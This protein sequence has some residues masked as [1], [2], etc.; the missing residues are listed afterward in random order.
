MLTSVFHGRGAMVL[1]DSREY[2]LC[3]VVQ[4]SLLLRLHF[5]YLGKRVR[6][7][8]KLEYDGIED[9]PHPKSLHE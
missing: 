3:V 1:P 8:I 6:D 2:I 9:L 5:D 7:K 4:V